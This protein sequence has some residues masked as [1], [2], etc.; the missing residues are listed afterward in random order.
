MRIFKSILS[1]M[2]VMII[3]SCNVS[4]SSS[5]DPIG[6]TTSSSTT[7]Q[8][9]NG[10]TSIAISSS[11]AL[12]QFIGLTSRVNVTASLNSSASSDTTLEWYVDN[13]RSLTQTGL[14]FEFFPTEVKTY[15]IQ[16]RS[17]G[18]ASNNL[19][20]SVGLPRFSLVNVE[21]V[22]N[23][24][25][26]VKA[27]SGISFSVSSLSLASS[28]SYNLAT[29]T[30]TLNL[31]SPMVQG[32]TYTLTASK[33]GF[34]N[35]VLPL[36]YET[37]RLTVGSILYRG[38]RV[39]AN[40]D[41][42]FEIQKPFA[43]ASSQNYTISLAQVN[44]EG[45]NVPI[46][47]ITN[48]PAGASAISP[49]QSAINIQR[50]INITRDYTLSNTT[51]PGLYVH[52]ISVNN[53]NL[54][55]RIVVSNPVASLTLTTP[56][57]YDLAATSGGGSAL[58]SPFALDA[59]GKTIKK[60]VTPN[61]TGQYVI[62]RPYN[63]SAFELTF[64]LTAD[65]FPTPIGFPAGA[66][67]Y[68]IIAAL[69]GPTGGIINY[70]S[71]FNT[72]A[73]TY[74]FRE[75]TGNAYRIS[76]YID[77]K[78]TLG[79]YTFTFNASGY[80]LNV[81][82]SIVIVIREFEPLIEPVIT[83]GNQTLKANS[84]GSFTIYKPLGVNTLDMGIS[85]K[86]SNYES[87]LASSFVGSAG[88]NTLYSDGTS[89][90]YLLDTRISYSG[91]L[92]SVTALVTKMAIELGSNSA[93]TTVTA[94]NGSVNFNRYFGAAASET[95]NLLA[96]RDIDTYTIASNT[97]VFDAMKTISATTFPGVHIYTVQIG[98]LVR[99]FTFRVVEPTPL[100]IIR[101]NVVEYGPNG[102]ESKDN[103]TYKEA[104][105][106][107]Y[108]NGKGGDLKINVL[109]FGMVTGDYNY[110]FTR[111]TPSGSFQ[112]TTNVARLTLRVDVVSSS[113]PPIVYSERYDGTLKFP[114]SGPGSEMQ[115]DQT[116]AEEG[117]YVYTF[118]INGITR[119]IRVVV[120]AAPQLRVEAL[121]FNNEPVSGFN[122]RFFVNNS[123]SSRYFE[124]ELTPINTK[125]TYKYILN[126]TSVL[127]IG[128]ALTS[129][130]QD[131]VIVNGKMVVGITVPSSTST[132]ETINTYLIALYDGTIQVGT[133]SKVVVV[134]QPLSSTI[135]FAA[136]GGVATTPKNQFVGTAVS[137]PTPPTR[138]GYNFVSWHL[139]PALVDTAVDFS[140]YLMPTSDTVIYAK[141]SSPIVYNIT[142]NLNSGTN[143]ASP[144][145]TYTIETP[146][147]VLGTPTK[148][149]S[150]FEGWFT[151]VGFTAGTQVTSIP[152]GSSGA[153]TL[154]AKFNP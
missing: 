30:Y 89:L 100:I 124:V 75:T 129:A 125:S 82:R 10:V 63:G 16:A 138:T 104:E 50:G 134:S 32:T 117:E 133:V 46:S 51:E 143:F 35:T 29:Q 41:G 19:T 128:A 152:L 90:R 101:D 54:V 15:Q 114:V 64:I 86:I 42:A 60:V 148:S 116:L 62:N 122:N 59:D 76:Q 94:Q 73:T 43:G 151:T 40:A 91:P 21:A 83:Y 109:P 6:S 127:P 95:I 31:L 49:F 85:V 150:T 154:Y 106:K 87:P 22:S 93:D 39:L 23:T 61:A 110:T 3:A 120:L 1:I 123:T 12:T 103:V 55:V 141:W 81:T 77:N 79:T 70:G 9:A 26:V 97:N 88:V 38:Q 28:S 147:I 135:F 108:V 5:N 65:N 58:S 18:V 84:D 57:V 99:A 102:S 45:S 69:S 8:V 139:N 145:A 13:V 144:P 131:L 115:V 25:I 107:Y 44:L 80:S 7:S 105:D 112:S 132:S 52:N 96:L 98:P 78:T 92:S 17:G 72:I 71:T 14:N 48:V 68:N 153:I 142:Y 53:I 118:L 149:G 4:S 34:E 56:V 24:Q 121:T 130:L 126:D 20:V 2:L 66:N 47:I 140:T 27:D 146:T 33:P 137:A 136:N 11:S 36:L 111:L 119:V 67:P 113:G 37:R 74:P